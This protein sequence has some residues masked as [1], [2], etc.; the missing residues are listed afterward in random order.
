MQTAFFIGLGIINLVLIWVLIRQWPR[1]DKGG[2]VGMTGMMFVLLPAAWAGLVVNH[3]LNEMKR[4]E[5]CQSCHV[6]TPYVAGIKNPETSAISTMHYQNNWVPQETACYSCHTSYSM[7]GPVKA[8]FNG[9]KHVWVNYVTG[10]PENIELYEPYANSDCLHCHAASRSFQ[11]EESHEE[12]E[13][14]CLDCHDAGHENPEP[15]L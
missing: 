7:F 15:T 12:M 8:K 4:V 3:S 1:L 9:L 10:P 11:L 6:M 14:S 13:D 5:F 2:R